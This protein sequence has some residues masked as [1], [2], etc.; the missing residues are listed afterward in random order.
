M[1]RPSTKGI[2]GTHT[3]RSRFLAHNLG[4]IVDSLTLDRLNK[5]SFFYD[6]RNASHVKGRKSLG[7][8]SNY[9]FIL[10]SFHEG[11]D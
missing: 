4:L 6:M 5:T 1:Y 7:V 10:Y 3:C 8:F 9:L 2:N 11:K